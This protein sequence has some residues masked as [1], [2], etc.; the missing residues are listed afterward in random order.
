MTPEAPV[1][2]V[3]GVLE[4]D[5]NERSPG[6]APPSPA[7][8]PKPK[9]EGIG[10]VERLVRPGLGACIVV[11]TGREPMGPTE[12]IGPPAGLEGA[13]REDGESAPPGDEVWVT[14]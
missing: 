12:P 5:E 9:G 14:G 2:T 13:C 1:E 6:P 3:V 10:V 8:K 4:A 7:V 11:G